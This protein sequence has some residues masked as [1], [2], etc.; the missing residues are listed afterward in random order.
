M[1]LA[2][3]ALLISPNVSSSIITAMYGIFTGV[4]IGKPAL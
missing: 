1:T 4:D 3:K 2:P